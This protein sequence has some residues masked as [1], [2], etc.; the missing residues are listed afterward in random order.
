MEAGQVQ[1]LSVAALQQVNFSLA[2]GADF[3]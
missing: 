3:A 2:F 1:S